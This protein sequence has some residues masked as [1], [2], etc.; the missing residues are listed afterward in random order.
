MHCVSMFVF[1]QVPG[2]NMNAKFFLIQQ[3]NWS[4]HCDFLDIEGSICDILYR[5][6]QSYFAFWHGGNPG[7]RLKNLPVSV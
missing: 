7:E 5:K 3:I 2:P 4:A 1:V 6:A